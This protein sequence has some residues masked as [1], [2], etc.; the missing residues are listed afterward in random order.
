MLDV[1]HA[2]KNMYEPWNPK[3]PNA[4]YNRQMYG[5]PINPLHNLNASLDL[6]SRKEC[7]ENK[8]IISTMK[9][10]GRETQGNDME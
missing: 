8:Q 10:N 4:S 9:R 5:Q 7:N 6:G 1:R 2:P 3:T